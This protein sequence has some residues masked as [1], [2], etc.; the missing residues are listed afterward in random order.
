MAED[1]WTRN[2]G[3]SVGSENGFVQFRVGT[4]GPSGKPR[5]PR[6][7]LALSPSEARQIAHALLRAADKAEAH[8]PPKQ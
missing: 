3:L 4:Q 8:Q 6:I 1:D 5:R 7:D 2:E